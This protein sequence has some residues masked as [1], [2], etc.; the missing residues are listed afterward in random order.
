MYPFKRVKVPP[1]LIKKLAEEQLELQQQVRL[2]PLKQQPQLI[3]ACDSSLKDEAIF[4]VFVLFSYPKLEILEV[5]TSWSKI[6]LPYI[7][8][9]L[10][11]REVP[12][13]LKAY[14][15]LTKQPELIFVDGHGIAHPR[16]LGIASHL[17]VKLG[18]PT[19]GIAKKVLVGQY[20]MPGAEVGASTDLKYKDQLVGYALRTKPK[21]KPV[22]VSPGHLINLEQALMYTKTTIGNYRLPSPTYIAD[23]LTKQLKQTAIIF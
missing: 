1:G 13:L 8:G 19:I 21:V 9:F 17:G 16:G 10:A 22:F 5:Q 7:P 6:E 23:K 2:T 20:E 18:K 15:Q 12:N 4:A 14:G 11:F 3:A